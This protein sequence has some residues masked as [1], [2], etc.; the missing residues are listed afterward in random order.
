MKGGYYIAALWLLLLIGLKYN[1]KLNLT[2]MSKEKQE[3]KKEADCRVC[4]EPTENRFNIS[5][6]AAPICEHCAVSIFLQQAAWYS[7]CN[8]KPPKQ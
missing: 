5:F 2:T 1:Q 4:G 8:I 3:V 6:S 7:K